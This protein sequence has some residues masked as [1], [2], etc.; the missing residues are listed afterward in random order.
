MTE[1]A[2]AVAATVDSEQFYIA[3]AIEWIDLRLKKDPMKKKGTRELLRASL[4]KTKELPIGDP[5]PETLSAL[6]HLYATY[7]KAFTEE[8]PPLAIAHVIR[9]MTA[10]RARKLKPETATHILNLIDRSKLTATLVSFLLV[11]AL[12]VEL[13]NQLISATSTL[14]FA[15]MTWDLPN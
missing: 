7:P 2:D 9:L 4:E 13:T 6:D 12:D 11:L 1:L 3:C 15:E 10:A 8:I 5:G 14:A